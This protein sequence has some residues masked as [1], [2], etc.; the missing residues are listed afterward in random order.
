VSADDPRWA[1][2]RALW[3]TAGERARVGSNGFQE[4]VGG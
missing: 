4:K 3:R 2:V 1:D